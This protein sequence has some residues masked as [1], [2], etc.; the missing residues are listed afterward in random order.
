LLQIISQIGKNNYK[1]S[2]VRAKISP[3]TNVGPK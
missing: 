3:S 2:V 1:W